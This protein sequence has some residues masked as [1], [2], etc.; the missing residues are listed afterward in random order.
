MGVDDTELSRKIQGDYLSRLLDEVDPN[1]GR[2]KAVFNSYKGNQGPT[3]VEYQQAI[4]DFTKVNPKFFDLESK[5][6]R[7]E[8]YFAREDAV[9]KAGLIK[10]GEKLSRNDYNQLKITSKTLKEIVLA[11]KGMR[12]GNTKP[13]WAGSSQL[14]RQKRRFD[15]TIN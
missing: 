15:K 2:Y 7:A 5:E 9:R 10:E 6:G 13:G 14:S 8:F 3:G 11:G 1:D 4:I 12:V